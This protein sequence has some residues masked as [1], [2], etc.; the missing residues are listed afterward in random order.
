MSNKSPVKAITVADPSNQPLLIGES[1]ATRELKTAK[2]KAER[3]SKIGQSL[4]ISKSESAFVDQPF[5][6]KGGGTA[7]YFWAASRGQWAGFVGISSL[8]ILKLN[9]LSEFR[10]KLD[11]NGYFKEIPDNTTLPTGDFVVPVSFIIASIDTSNNFQPLFAVALPD[12]TGNT[13]GLQ[14]YS[15]LNQNYDLLDYA[16]FSDRTGSGTSTV[17]VSNPSKLTEPQAEA[18]FANGATL[19]YGVFVDLSALSGDTL[20]YMTNNVINTVNVFRQS[21]SLSFNYTGVQAV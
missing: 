20:T 14:T 8:E 12:A 17:F 19:I 16:L 2:L 15:Y 3:A 4:L 10:L 1:Q 9:N 11:I 6:N 5:Q 13:G 21:I 7:P 18:I